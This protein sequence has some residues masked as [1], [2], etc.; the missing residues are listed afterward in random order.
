MYK[1]HELLKGGSTLRLGERIAEIIEERNFKQSAIA[2]AAGYDRRV[3]N[4]IIKGRRMVKGD[5]IPSICNALLI[6]ANTLFAGVR[7]ADKPV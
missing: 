7:E 5:E 1:I 4:D 6:D 2:R 3:F